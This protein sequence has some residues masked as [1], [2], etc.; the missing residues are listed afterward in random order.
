MYV[1]R[2]GLGV[3]VA[4]IL[5]LSRNLTARSCRGRQ[6]GISSPALLRRAPPRAAR[7]QF[8][9]GWL[10]KIVESRRSRHVRCQ[11]LDHKCDQKHK[12]FAQEGSPPTWPHRH[13]TLPYA[14]GTLG[15]VCG[16][17]AHKALVFRKYTDTVLYL[18]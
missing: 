12:H 18:H 13:E 9:T 5:A 3:R 6:V 8:L 2:T 16:R 14:S 11:R 7:N 1:A 10:L 17:I 15:S 4:V